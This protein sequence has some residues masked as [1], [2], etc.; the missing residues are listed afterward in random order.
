MERYRRVVRGNF[1][2]TFTYKERIKKQAVISAVIF[3]II[4][5]IG[6]LKTKPANILTDRVTDAISYT[7]DYQSATKDVVNAI[8]SF[9]KEVR[10]AF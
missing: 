2:N 8:L 5:C 3:L 9:A 10:N 6:L 4:F 7:V 1:E